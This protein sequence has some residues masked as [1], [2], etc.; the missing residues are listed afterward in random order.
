M[1]NARGLM[2]IAGVALL[3]LGM[4]WIYRPL[5]LVTLGAYLIFDVYWRAR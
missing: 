1:E 3:A 2:T 5:G 4:A